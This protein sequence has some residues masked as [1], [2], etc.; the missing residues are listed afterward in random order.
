MKILMPGHKLVG[1]VALMQQEAAGS[2]CTVGG[3]C[4]DEHSTTTAAGEPTGSSMEAFTRLAPVRLITFYLIALYPKA[5]VDE[6]AET[7]ESC[8]VA[9]ARVQWH[10]LGSLPSP[11][12]RFKRFSCLNLWSSWDYRWSLTLLPRL[13]CN[14]AILAHCNLRLLVS[15]YSPASASEVAGITGMHHHARL[16]FVS[17]V[18]TGFHHHFGRPR[19]VDHLRSGVRDQPG[20]HGETPFLLKIQKLAGHAFYLFTY[21]FIYLF[22]RRGFTLSPRLKCSVTIIAHCNLN[23]LGSSRPPA[24]ASRIAGTTSVH[25]HAW[26]IFKFCVEM[27]F[28]SVEL[29]LLGLGNPPTSASQSVRMTGVSHGAQLCSISCLICKSCRD[30]PTNLFANTQESRWTKDC[31]LRPETIKILEDNIGKTLLDTVLGKDF[32]TKN[33]KANAAKTKINRW[34]LIKLKS[35]CPAKEMIRRNKEMILN[36]LPNTSRGYNPLG[37]CRK[38]AGTCCSPFLFIRGLPHPHSMAT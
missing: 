20:Q 17:L 25:H 38:V 9:Q 18:E 27:A 28:H 4:A 21:L 11:P 19:R 14:G 6:R 12:P 8:S 29:E 16:I 10:D 30:P 33:L 36:G 35:F 23:L 7:M 24:S 2:Q 3:A 26:L 15:N 37:Q 22:M 32:M 5:P 13:Q 31:N 34:D 1:T